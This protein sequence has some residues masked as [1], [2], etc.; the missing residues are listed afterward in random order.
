MEKSKAAMET[1]IIPQYCKHHSGSKYE[2][3]AAS[4]VHNINDV[5]ITLSENIIGAKPW[6]PNEEILKE[7]VIRVLAQHGNATKSKIVSADTI[8]PLMK[9]IDDLCFPGLLFPTKQINH[10]FH[11]VLL[12]ISQV[13][14]AGHVG[15]TQALK[16]RPG[17]R[18]V[19]SW[20]MGPSILIRLS[21]VRYHGNGKKEKLTLLEVM[22]VAVHEMIH[23]YLI[24]LSCRHEQCGADFELM[25]RGDG[26]GHGLAFVALL[27][28]VLGQMQSWAPVMKDFG[29]MDEA[30]HPYEDFSVKLWK[31]GEGIKSRGRA[32]R[33]WW[34]A[35]QPL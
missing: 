15:W 23:A 27:K 19:G 18:A 26:D 12:Q 4:P 33:V 8:F 13:P 2:Y 28:A 20:T 32:Q 34:L 1:R 3:P 5:A 17:S 31:R 35:A 29:M 30:I 9:T 7:T 21:T 14:Q 10:L 11:P 16:V 25:H 22:Q 6:A 24:L